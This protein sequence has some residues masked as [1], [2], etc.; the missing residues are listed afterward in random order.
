[1]YWI[2][3]A[4]FFFGLTYG[5]LQV[6]TEF[7]I[8]RR[9]RLVNL[10]VGPYVMSKV[11]VLLPLL[12]MVDVGMLVVLWL[13]NRLPTANVAV[14]GSLSAT[15]VLDSAAALGIGLLT[16][17]VVTRPEQATLALPMICFPQVLF[18]GAFLAVPVMAAAGQVISYAMTDRWAFEA[19]GKTL[20]LNQ[21]L[22]QGGSPLG[23]P[24]LSQYGD[25][26][27]RAT[28]V[29]WLILGCIAFLALGATCYILIRRCRAAVD[30]IST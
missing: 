23:R 18:S 29:N 9:E 20:N 6:C 14:Y 21:L 22:R 11:A 27:S 17:A 13:F 7:P 12:V 30:G 28:G 3:F 2:A 8:L 25:T 5:L 16:S 10:G 24:L 4:G 19:L 26:F 15:L 1:V